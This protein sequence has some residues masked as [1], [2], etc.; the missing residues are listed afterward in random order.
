MKKSKKTKSPAVKRAAPAAA[1]SGRP[2]PADTSRRAFITK[3]RNWGIG[4]AVL[5]GAG[6]GVA[7]MARGTA[8]AHD[9]TRITNGKPT[10]VQIHDPQCTLCVA[11]QRETKRALRSFDD[12]Q[13]D[14]VIAN[15]TSAK[16][17]AFASRYRVG[18][19]TLLLFDETGTLQNTLHGQYDSE[20]LREEFGKL[21][22]T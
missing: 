21:V 5:G 14:Y 16:G 12:E 3:A 6:F 8:E 13:L 4:F 2:D 19:V 17:R 1:Q 7:Q 20:E 10:I 11:L 18:H 22:G 9:L 15:V